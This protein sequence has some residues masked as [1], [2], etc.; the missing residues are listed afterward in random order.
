MPLTNCTEP[1]D[2]LEAD[3]SKDT[4]KPLDA[5]C[6]GLLFRMRVATVEKYPEADSGT[7]ITS[8]SEWVGADAA[9]TTGALDR[10]GSKVG[11]ISNDLGND[12]EGQ[13]LLDHFQGTSVVTTARP[14]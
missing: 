5:V 7:P 6:L 4:S 10:L 2:D 9:I 14:E 12:P 13:A 1:V 3:I 8:L 11:L